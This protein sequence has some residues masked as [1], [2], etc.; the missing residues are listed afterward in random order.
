MAK[1]ENLHPLDEANRKLRENL[2][3]TDWHNPEP[4]ERYNLLVVGGG[5]A[6]LVAASGAAGLGA[7]VALVEKHLMGGDCLNVGC[8]PSKSVIHGSRIMHDLSEAREMG[9]EIPEPGPEQFAATWERMRQVRVRISEND[10]ARS[11]SEKGIDLFLGDGRFVDAH[12]FEVDGKQIRFKKALVCTGGRPKGLDVDGA[13]ETGYLTNETVFSITERPGR[14]VVLGGGPIGCELSQAF[15]RLGTQVTIISDVDQFLPKEDP[16][17]ATILRDQFEREGIAMHFSAQ[18]ERLE[19]RE[20]EKLV[21]VVLGSG[22][23]ETIVCDEILVAIGRAPNV[24][25][26]GLENANV[27][28]HRHGIAINDRFQTTAPH[29]FA[30]GDVATRYKFTHAADFAA[31][32]VIQNA[33]FFGRKKLSAMNMPWCTYT[34]PEIAHVGMYEADA[35]KKGIEVDTYKTDLADVDRAICE[36]EDHGFVKIHVEK[37]K[38]KILGATIVANHA[39]EMISEISVAMA[40]G[41]GLGGLASVIHPYPTQAEAIRLTGDAYNRTR[42]TPFVAGLFKKWLAWTR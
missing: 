16:D 3:P 29:I 32:A 18:V 37:G 39:G 6:G 36:N 27:E 19:K 15:R 28:C 13:E 33:L 7:K 25:G 12:C 31:R 1:L 38:D 41:L 17:A 4:Q 8:V 11:L 34:S 40:A 14:L 21:H 26:L 9:M 22:E 35:R 42:L 20:G 23:N 10:S 30:A 2:R 24:E 5:P